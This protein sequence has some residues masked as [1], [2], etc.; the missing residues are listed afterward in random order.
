VSSLPFARLDHLVIAVRDLDAAAGAYAAVLGRAASWRGTHPTYGTANVLFGLDNCYLE[1]LALGSPPTHPVATALAAYLER[2]AEGLFALAFGSDD[3]DA[4]ADH[5][6]SH[7]LHPGPIAD[8]EAHA[9]GGAL[10]RWRSF[11]LPRVDT[12]GVNVFVIAH[13][14]RATIAT[15]VPSADPRAVVTGVDHVVVFSDDLGAALRLWGETFRIPERWRRELPERGTVNV[16]LRLGGVT[17]ELVGPLAGATGTRGERTWG[18]AYDVSDV[19]AAVARLRAS[20]IP[21]SEARTG[22]A[23]ATRVSTVKWPDGVPTLLI[24]HQARA[25]RNAPR[26]RP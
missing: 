1:L 5:L 24:E 14:D 13:E 16:G 7:G 23:P 11:A 6:R 26:S 9:P 8:G 21:V 12:R 18:L 4:A 2:H 17:F 20:G 25:G 15:A 10:R 3:L 22:L 19:D